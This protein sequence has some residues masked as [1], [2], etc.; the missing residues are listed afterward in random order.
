[1]TALSAF[2]GV[3]TNIID[4]IVENLK[5]IINNN[6]RDIKNKLINFL[7]FPLQKRGTKTGEEGREGRWEL[8]SKTV[9]YGDLVRS[10]VNR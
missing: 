10:G 1:M 2:P 7:T 5:S 4:S 8:R 9:R 6:A 3:I